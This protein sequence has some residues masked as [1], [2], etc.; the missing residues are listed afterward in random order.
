MPE[1][2]AAILPPDADHNCFGCGPANQCGL[3]L[4]FERAGDGVRA[5][6]VPRPQDEGFAGIVHGGIL[7]AMLDEAMAWATYADG[8]W[9]MTARMAVRFRKPVPVGAE[10]E[11]SGRVV[12]VRGQVV[13]TV[14]D[15]R[16]ADGAVLADATAT[17]LRVPAETAAAW[18][19]RYFG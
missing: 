18:E 11:I 9:A 14:G 19:R 15:I 4:R 3:R 8:V 7:S 1:P 12:L 13:E 16:D 6:F 5:L 17:F 10:L 2:T